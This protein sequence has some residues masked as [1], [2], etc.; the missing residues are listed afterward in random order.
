MTSLL[1]QQL[2]V[3]KSSLGTVNNTLA[4]VK[5]NKG[6]L[7]EGTNKVTQYMNTLKLDTMEKNE[8]NWC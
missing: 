2:Y 5:Y 3:V 1:K 7:K 4:Y 8:R 6:L